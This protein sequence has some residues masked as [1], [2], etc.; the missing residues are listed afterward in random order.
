MVEL[1][2]IDAVEGDENEGAETEGVE[3][4]G[5]ACEGIYE[6]EGLLDTVM[7]CDG[8][9]AKAVAEVP[10]LAGPALLTVD[11]E[12]PLLVVDEVLSKTVLV[13]MGEDVVSDERII[14]GGESLNV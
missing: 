12:K 2:G 8:V 1:E 6:V 14:V 5:A 13:P 3:T 7:G 11:D 4:D 10:W 9:A